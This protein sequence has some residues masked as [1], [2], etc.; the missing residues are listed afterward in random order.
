MASF[1]SGG[2]PRTDRRCRPTD[3]PKQVDD[4]ARRIAGEVGRVDRSIG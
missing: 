1:E 4:D 3:N 2:R